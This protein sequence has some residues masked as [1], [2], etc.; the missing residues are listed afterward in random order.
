MSTLIKM[1]TMHLYAEETRELA[2]KV[3][4]LVAIDTFYYI[5]LSTL[6]N[7]VRAVQGHSK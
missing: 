5:L 6:G 4:D 3:N 2:R 1:N 7:I